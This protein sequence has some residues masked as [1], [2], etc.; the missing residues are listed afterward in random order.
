MEGCSSIIAAS[1]FS[2]C[3]A[4]KQPPEVFCIR[5]GDL[6]N[7]AKFTGKHL[8][9]CGFCEISKNIVFTEHLWVSA[10]VSGIVP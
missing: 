3:S 1:Q 2:V 7:F 10:S 4:E 9:S 5:K 6:R 8:F